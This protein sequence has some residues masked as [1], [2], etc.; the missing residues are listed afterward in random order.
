M[1][2]SPHVSAQLARER[3]RD[4]LAS[5][6]QQRQARRLAAESRAARRAGRAGRQLRLRRALRITARA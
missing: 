6:G 1:L 2:T 3:Q 5:A 4:M